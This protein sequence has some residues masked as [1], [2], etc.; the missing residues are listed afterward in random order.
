M[1]D[2]R[3]KRTKVLPD[4]LALVDPYSDKTLG[5]RVFYAG[6]Q[7]FLTPM[8]IPGD[9]DYEFMYPSGPHS[10]L[11]EEHAN[12]DHFRFSR[13]PRAKDLLE[14]IYK[15]W[16]KESKRNRGKDEHTVLAKFKKKVVEV[17][18]AALSAIENRFPFEAPGKYSI[19]V[20]CQYRKE[21]YIHFN[22]QSA[23]SV[24]TF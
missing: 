8:K 24:L 6:G 9:E 20:T 22:M 7:R 16:P 14:M 10:Y 3:A 21:V 19:V 11:S 15:F 1:A 17:D 4:H 23:P 5:D 18:F 2:L 13:K 12:T